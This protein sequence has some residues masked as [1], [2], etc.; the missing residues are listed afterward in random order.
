[1]KEILAWMERGLG[2]RPEEDTGPVVPLTSR[3]FPELRGTRLRD[4]GLCFQ[5]RR[6]HPKPFILIY[7]E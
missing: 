4:A 5:E 1:M 2:W 6:L 7:L 3:P